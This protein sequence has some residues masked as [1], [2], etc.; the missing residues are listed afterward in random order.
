LTPHRHDYVNITGT[1]EQLVR[2]S[3][4]PEGLCPGHAMH[5]TASAVSIAHNAF[6]VERI[7]VIQRI[8]L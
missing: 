1:I 4:V 5:I 3:G 7:S 2:K 6:V 8:I